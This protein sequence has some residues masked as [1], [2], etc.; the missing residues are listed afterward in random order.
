MLP[1]RPRAEPSLSDAEFIRYSR[2]LMLGEDGEIRQLRLKQAKVLLLGV[3]GLGCPVATTLVNAGIGAIT[4]IDSDVVELSNLPRQSLYQTSEI[5]QPKAKVAAARLHQHNPHPQL[6]VLQCRPDAQQLSEL[7]QACDL[8]ID[9]SDNLPTRLQLN[10]LAH[11]AGKPLFAGAVSGSAAQLYL[12]SPATACYQCLVDPD[13]QALQ[14]CRTLGVDPALVALTA[15]QLALLVLHYLQ[16]GSAERHAAVPFGH[17][18][19]YQP[20]QPGQNSASG[21]Q[22]YPVQADPN[23]G[24]CAPSFATPGV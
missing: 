13:W 12:F 4:L 19:R 7:A 17:Y 2:S 15:Q 8:L 5:G 3:G 1:E 9:C 6:R 22:W 16:T 14:N 24:C 21:F 11:A 18:G 23:C 20:W 10:T